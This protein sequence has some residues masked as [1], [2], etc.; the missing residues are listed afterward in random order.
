MHTHASGSACL[1]ASMDIPFQD[2][3]LLLYYCQSELIIKIFH[4]FTNTC[5]H[6][7]RLGTGGGRLWMQ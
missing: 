6:V 1:Y 7:L 4:F 3:E 2:L 5:H